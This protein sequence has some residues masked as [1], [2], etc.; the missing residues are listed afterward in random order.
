MSEGLDSIAGG[1]RSAAPGCHAWCSFNREVVVQVA[2][3]SLLILVGL[4]NRFAEKFAEAE[5]TKEE[6]KVTATKFG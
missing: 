2:V 4:S 1:K 6:T 5:K 3:R